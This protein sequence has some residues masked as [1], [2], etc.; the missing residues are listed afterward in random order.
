MEIAWELG[1]PEEEVLEW[2]IE[3]VMRWSSFFRIAKP[4]PK[5]NRRSVRPTKVN[6]FDGNQSRPD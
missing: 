5:T 2:P 4:Q 6:Y 3:K 1:I